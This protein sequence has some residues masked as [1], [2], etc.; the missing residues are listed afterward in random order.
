MLSA[1]EDEAHIIWLDADVVEISANLVQ[2]M[3]TQSTSHPH[4][5]IITAACH[6]NKME[7]YDKN[8]WKVNSPALMDIIPDSAR[9]AAVR[10]LV[11]RRYFV[12]DLYSQAPDETLI[13]LDSVGGTILYIRSELIRQGVSFPH[14]NIVGTTWSQRGWIG[15]ETE[16]ICYAAKDLKGGGCY[17]LGGKHH[18]RH[19]DWG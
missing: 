13:Q 14:F 6:Q 4:A 10:D 5:G 18:V 12:P 7:N 2:T 8:A 9:P 15:V 11:K 17:A 1:L 19:T 3:I 16:G